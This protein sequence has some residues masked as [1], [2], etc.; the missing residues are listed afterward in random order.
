MVI[1]GLSLTVVI[2]DSV[3]WIRADYARVLTIAEWAA[4][5]FFTVEYALRLICV[6][7]PWRYAISFYGIVDLLAI[8]P[9]WLSLLVPG[10]QGLLVVRSLRL[11]R[12]FR[13]LKLGHF[14]GEGRVLASAMRQ[15]VPKITIFLVTVLSLVIIFAAVM[16]LVEG[17]ENG[18][19]D[20][21]TSMYWAI[22]TMTTVGFG[23]IT[24]HTAIGKFVASVLM[25]CGY[26]ILA[27]PTGIVSVELAAVHRKG[28]NT[29][30]CPSCS[31]DGHDDDAVHCKYCGATL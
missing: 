17:P 24:P 23:D 18:F 13:I 26:A 15:S 11:L 8:L 30:S 2:L 31:A 12:I 14:V 9:T 4:T 27:V 10:G 1:I 21:P 6:R 16:Y 3:E 25:L 28:L 22:V 20:I 29:R 5:V 19:T 7:R